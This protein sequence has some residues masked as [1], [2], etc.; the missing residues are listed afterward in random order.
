MITELEMQA[1]YLDG[2]PY[3]RKDPI[4]RY[5]CE[6]HNEPTIYIRDHDIVVHTNTDSECR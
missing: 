5:T 6:K 1:K 4:E 2:T 3:W